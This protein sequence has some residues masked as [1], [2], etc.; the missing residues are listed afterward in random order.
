[1]YV[2]AAVFWA[3]V[4]TS[5]LVWLMLQATSEAQ[6]VRYALCPFDRDIATAPVAANSSELGRRI[7]RDAAAAYLRVC[8]DQYGPLPPVDLDAYLPAPPTPPNR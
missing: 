2:V 6:A 4:L 8:V 7:I 5:L 1:M 3:G